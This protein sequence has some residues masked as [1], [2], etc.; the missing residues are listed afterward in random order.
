MLGLILL[1]WIGKNFYKLAEKYIKNKWGY[2]FL[3][4][5]VY[6]AGTLLFGFILGII[7]ELTSPGYIETMNDFVLGLIAIPFGLITCYSLYKILENAWRNKVLGP[8]DIIENPSHRV[9]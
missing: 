7:I 6:Y 2:A 4:I 8:D 3:G 5:G 1:Y 9:K